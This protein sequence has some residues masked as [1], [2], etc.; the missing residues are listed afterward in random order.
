M[1]SDAKFWDDIAEK[2]A[3]Q[4]V[5]DVAAF[6]R[7]K[8]ITR[9]LLRPNSAVLELGCGTGSLALA[10]APFAR[11]IHALDVSSEMIRLADAKKKDA[12]ASNVTF[13][14]GTLERGAQVQRESFDHVWAFSLLHLVRDRRQLLEHVFALLKPGGWFISSNVCLG[15]SLVPYGA[16]ISVMRWFGKAPLVFIYKRATI[17]REFRECGFS[18]IEDR[19][20]GASTTI[21][22]LLAKKPT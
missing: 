20:V 14:Q 1:S 21:A 19:D 6:E 8:A 3:A 11:H 5:K 7:K 10:M 2:Y 22:F 15:D 13:C 18:Q 4:P 9:E 16:L 17:L 12:G